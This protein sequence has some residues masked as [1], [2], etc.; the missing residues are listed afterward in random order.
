[1]VNDACFVL[2][3]I[4]EEWDWRVLDV[5][6]NHP[7]K[8][9]AITIKIGIIFIYDGSIKTEDLIGDIHD[10]I[11]PAKID[12]MERRIMGIMIIV[13]SVMLIILALDWDDHIVATL[14]RIE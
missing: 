13:F 4:N 14:N 2:L 7:V 12:K 10:I 5:L 1:M 8:L 3:L 11:L 9:P 6:S